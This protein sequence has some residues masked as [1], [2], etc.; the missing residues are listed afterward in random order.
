MIATLRPVLAAGIAVAAFAGP[1]T[2]EDIKIGFLGGITGPIESLVPPIVDGAQLALRHVNEQG[3]L[4]GGNNAV[5]V[6]GDTTCADATK[7]ADAADRVVNVDKVV[8]IVGALCSG[9]TISA[10]NNAAIPGG[11]V[12]ISP[13]STSPAITTMDDKDLV[14]RTATSDA[15]QGEVLARLIA[16]KGVTNI[17][18]TYVNND[19]GKGLAE[20]LASAFPNNGGT[21]AVNEA[22]EDGKA[23]Y[24]SE[25]GS[26][27]ASGVTDL[28]I[29]GYADGS[30]GTI[31][32]QALETGDFTQ[33]FSADGMV[34]DKIAA[35][36]GSQLEGKLVM[37]KP[38]TPEIPGAASF[39]K[40]AADAGVKADG[41][42]VPN[43]YDAAFIIALAIEQAG[44][45]DRAE[46]AKHIRDVASA[47]GD[48]ILPGE[49]AK[50]VEAIKAG[51][52]VNYEGAAGGHDFDENGD[53]STV[54]LHT[55]V[56]D[57]KVVEL[58]LAE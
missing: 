56:K 11:V 35:E 34:S 29:I 40:L 7:A 28:V 3:G 19:Y 14:Y 17:A 31:L 42:F 58:G 4:L 39:N 47:P 8:A 5:L 24:R 46:I 36:L 51:R 37:T 52:G 50:A 18:I 44:S 38:G 22:H 10:A 1:A 57:G 15:Y 9:A 49:W 55:E 6:V 41:V 25:L 20:S 30:G 26:L 16:S 32:R 43:S 48:V 2:A 12:M 53:V 45:T 54:F 33:F 21:V 13:A 27:A 23:D